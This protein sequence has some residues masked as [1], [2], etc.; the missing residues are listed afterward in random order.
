MFSQAYS[1]AWSHSFFPGLWIFTMTKF[2]STK[3]L[4]CIVLFSH[5]SIPTCF[6]NFL[7]A[8]VPITTYF[9][10]LTLLAFSLVALTKTTICQFLAKLPKLVLDLWH[11][12]TP[13]IWN[14]SSLV[15][16]SLSFE[17]FKQNLETHHFTCLGLLPENESHRFKK[18]FYWYSLTAKSW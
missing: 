1:A 17:T 2:S 16:Q 11:C 13:T 3:V 8:S 4:Y 12:I 9:A 15:R 6:S 18:L 14:S 5:Q 7:I 10:S